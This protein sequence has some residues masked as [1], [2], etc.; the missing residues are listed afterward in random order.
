MNR[1]SSGSMIS[2]TETDGTYF[3]PQK[4]FVVI[5]RLERL[6]NKSRSLRT[7]ATHDLLRKPQKHIRV[8]RRLHIIFGESSVSRFFFSFLTRP[9]PTVSVSVQDWNQHQG[10]A[11]VWPHGTKVHPSLS[12]SPSFLHES[13][14]SHSYRSSPQPHP[15]LH[16]ICERKQMTRLA[17]ARLGRKLQPTKL[18]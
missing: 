3:P 15:P 10:P 7:S 17:K 4:I 18:N 14:L 16:P 11:W 12:V 9:H 8:F 2:V 6:K 5:T 13:F 1:P